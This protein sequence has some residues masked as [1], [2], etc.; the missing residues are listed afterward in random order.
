MTGVTVTL[1]VGNSADAGAEPSQPIA[2]GMTASKPTAAHASA[3]RGKVEPGWEDI[4]GSLQRNEIA[5]L[6]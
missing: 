5:N 3:A 4:C 6:T 1:G 2:S